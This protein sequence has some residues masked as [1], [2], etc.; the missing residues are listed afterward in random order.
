[1]T[2][3]LEESALFEALNAKKMSAAEI[4]ASFVILGQFDQLIGPDHSFLVGPRGS[5]KTTLMRMLQGDCLMLWDHRRA[6]EYRNR[7]RYS[8]VFLPADRLWASQVFD[9]AGNNQADLL[10]ISAFC[11]QALTS[12]IETLQYRIGYFPNVAP[13]HLPAD[14]RHRDE[15]E[16]VAE[17]AEAWGLDV[18]SASLNGLL[19]ALDR[20]LSTIADLLEEDLDTGSEYDLLREHSWLSLRPIPAFTFGLRLIN[21]MTRQPSHRWALLLDEMELAPEVVHR[22]LVAAMRGGEKNLVLKLSFS[23][24]DRYIASKSSLGAPS[25]DNDYRAIY[26]WYGDRT[27]SRKFANGIWRRL[28]TEIV[29]TVRQ[30]VHV[31]GSSQIDASGFTWQDED[32]GPKSKQVRLIR[33]LA[34]RDPSFRGYL[35]HKR[36]DVNRLSELDYTTRS[37]TL[38]KIYPLLVFR[39]A[40]VD[41]DKGVGHRRQRKKISEVFSGVDAVFTALEG[42]PRWMKA[43]FTRLL[44]VYDGRH[45]IEEGAQYDI[46]R[47]ASD[48]FEALLRVL[49][50]SADESPFA[51]L[52]LVDLIARFFYTRMTGEFSADPALT[53]KVD[54]DVPP[55]V[56]ATLKTALAA[57]AIVHLRE[58]KSPPVLSSLY[59]ERFRLAYLLCIRDHLEVPMRL[60]KTV[61]L[62]FILQAQVKSN[63]INDNLR[64]AILLNP[65]LPFVIAESP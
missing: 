61:D 40:L 30:P 6:S 15:V 11:T 46:L 34:Y 8:S 31:L 47:E 5:G 51:V 13:V 1:M 10:G 58:K 3:S 41:F 35:Q 36:I 9:S 55:E 57:G 44:S 14:L 42:N 56:I 7:I 38:R 52:D 16:L 54:D 27:G 53:F 26:L 32:Y 60:G 48:R 43:V 24:F 63:F 50:I 39:D 28:S 29:G 33:T 20:R 45:V 59:G 64:A 62:S 19:S 4:A 37:A 49:P 23:P 12:L 25:P 21:R 18:R 2:E 65:T 22:S 17:C